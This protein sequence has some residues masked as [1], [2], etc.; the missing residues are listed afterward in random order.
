MF[1]TE[2]KKRK[3]DAENGQF[4]DEWA[5]LYFMNT[6]IG[7]LVCLLCRESLSV[8]KE[9][10]CKRHYETKHAAVY[11]E[12]NADLRRKKIEQLTKTLS[13]EQSVFTRKSQETKCLTRSSCKVAQI[14]AKSSQ[15]L[16]DGDFVR[17]CLQSICTEICSENASLFSKVPSSRMTI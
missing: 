2:A 3:I 15:P 5:F 6:F 4:N 13:V 10:N 9:F 11:N 8:M 14:I 1:K 17:E 7:Q 16:T 12:L